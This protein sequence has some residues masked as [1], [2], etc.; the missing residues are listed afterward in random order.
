MGLG[1]SGAV[2]RKKFI[3]MPTNKNNL[4]AVCQLLKKKTSFFFEVENAPALL[5]E[6]RCTV[7]KYVESCCRP[8]RFNTGQYKLGQTILI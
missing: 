4:A 3:F 1:G 5:Q 7:A 2:L 6:L 8:P